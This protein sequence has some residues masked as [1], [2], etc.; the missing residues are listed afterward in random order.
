MAIPAFAMRP[1]GCWRLRCAIGRFDDGGA[2]TLRD[3]DPRLNALLPVKGL[4]LPAIPLMASDLTERCTL[5]WHPQVAGLAHDRLRPR[6]MPTVS[7]ALSMELAS[8]GM[9]AARAFSR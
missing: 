3:V 8:A 1:H 5:D 2:A 6:R 9:K 4:A 7:P